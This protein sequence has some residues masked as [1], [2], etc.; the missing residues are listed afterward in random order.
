MSLPRKPS[1]QIWPRRVSY[2]DQATPNAKPLR[3]T[4]PEAL[5]FSTSH[6]VSKHFT[7]PGLA[8]PGD[9]PTASAAHRTVHGA[10]G[11][12]KQWK[13]PASVAAD[14]KM[15]RCGAARWCASA[16]MD[17]TTPLAPAAA[18]GWL[19]RPISKC[20]LSE[21]FALLRLRCFKSWSKDTA[22]SMFSYLARR[23][24]SVSIPTA[25]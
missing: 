24:M 18:P 12:L 6:L 2:A 7:R 19:W 11:W 17:N 25:C 16:C 15:G 3:P 5:S 9:G 8:W 20:W 23:R 14:A 10:G 13:Q 4:S 1:R 22:A 21:V